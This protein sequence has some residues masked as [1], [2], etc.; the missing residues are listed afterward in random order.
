MPSLHQLGH[1]ADRVLD[2][3]VG[4]DAVLVVEVDRLDA[5]P[6][7]ARLAA[8]AARSPGLPLTPRDIG[9]SGSRTMPNLVAS[10]TWSRRPRIALA[11]QLLVGERAVHVGGVEES[12]AELERA[13][14][15]RDRLGVVAAAVEVGHAHAAEAH[16][17]DLEAAAS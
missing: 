17:R 2:R 3:R 11:D 4:I 16:G 7:Q 15:G 6:L 12:D 14:D 9:S 1:R 13:V 5:E 10:T 8:T